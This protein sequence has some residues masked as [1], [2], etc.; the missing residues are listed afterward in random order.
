MSNKSKKKAKLTNKAKNNSNMKNKYAPNERGYLEEKPKKV[1]SHSKNDS[2][3]LPDNVTDPIV[4]NNIATSE[5]NY[6]YNDED[7]I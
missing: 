3:E 5:F 2:V 1:R 4:S 6:T 7:D